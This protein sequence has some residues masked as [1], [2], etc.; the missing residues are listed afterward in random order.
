MA[1]KPRPTELTVHQHSKLLEVGFDDGAV[2]GIP[3]EL[4]RIYSPS[5]E[6]QG[7]SSG[8]FSWEYLYYLGSR[9]DKLWRD[10]EARIEGAGMSRDA[11]MTSAAGAGCGHAH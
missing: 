11:P 2:F 6:V 10:Y 9:Q 1:E 8:I 7:H 3:F 5:A 4:M